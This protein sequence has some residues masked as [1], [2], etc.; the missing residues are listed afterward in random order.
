MRP[1]PCGTGKNYTECCG[2]FIEG[3]QKPLTPEALMRSRYTAYTQANTDYLLQTAKSP[4]KDR[5]DE[6]LS[7]KWAKQ[8]EWIG[9]EVKNAST[10]STKGFVEFI[11]SF[12]ENGKLK[13]IHELSEFHYEDSVWYYVDGKHLPLNNTTSHSTH[14]G[15]N[16]LCPCGSG[17]KYKKCCLLS[18]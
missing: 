16:D 13:A 4:A 14:I 7:R 5:F 17:K 1:C 3:Q 15:R 12:K 8:V 6:Q 2:V 18:Q 9:L 10:E 11:A